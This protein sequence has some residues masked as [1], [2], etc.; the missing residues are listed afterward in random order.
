MINFYHTLLEQIRSGSSLV[1]AT[2]VRAKGSIPQKPGS[3]A[4]FGEKGLIAGT[5]G[6]GILEGEVHHI[7]ANVMISEISDQFYFNLDNDENGE[8]AICGGD[9]EVLVDA[10]PSKHLTIF[11]AMEKS[12]SDHLQGYLLTTVSH[13][14]DRGR[15]IRRYWIGQE[16]DYELPAGLEAP[17]KA[18]LPGQMKQAARY[19]FTEVVVD[20]ATP[21]WC[22]MAFLEHIKPLPQLIIAGGGHVGKALAHLGSLL[23]FE[24]TVADDRPEY[25]SAD[26]IP[27]ADHLVVREIGSAIR[28][29][30]KDRDTYI[31][32]VTRGH[33]QDSEALKACIGSDVAYIGMMGSAHKVRIIKKK[34]LEN[35]WA[36][37][38]AWS[39]IHTPI[40]VPIGSETIQEIAISIAAQ[41]VGVRNK[42]RD[43]NVE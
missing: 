14:H 4:L 32:I 24:V 7:A 3:S 26:H 37:E 9:S 29:I 13:K 21:G 6:G 27:D 1:L 2:V 34:F 41:L 8:G 36:S 15:S 42:N 23:E 18:V 35:G 5:V 31:V 25:A 43:E 22:E 33:H 39:S 11:E 17:L 19:G 40:G 20:P 12:L 38:E 16:Q 30:K 10:D 28:E